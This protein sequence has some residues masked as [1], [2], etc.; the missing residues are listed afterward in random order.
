[1]GKHSLGKMRI[2]HEEIIDKTMGDCFL[3]NKV[4]EAR[5]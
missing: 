5:K 2:M 1:M 3:Q 4:I